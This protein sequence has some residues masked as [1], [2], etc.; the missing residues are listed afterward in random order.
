[1]TNK[2]AICDIILP[3][4]VSFFITDIICIWKNYDIILINI[5][6]AMF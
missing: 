6:V 2:E 3:V 1:M 5:L 4:S